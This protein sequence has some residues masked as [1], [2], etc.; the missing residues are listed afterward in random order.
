MHF[1]T[2]GGRSK[3]SLFCDSDD[4]GVVDDG[5]DVGL[6]TYLT[7]NSLCFSPSYK[8]HEFLIGQN[9]PKISIN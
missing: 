1:V 6:C 4:D 8:I 2:A 3:S 7:H 5:D 9:M